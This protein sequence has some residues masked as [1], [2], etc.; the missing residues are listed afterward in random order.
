MEA[1]RFN[2]KV[3][4]VLARY[5][6]QFVYLYVKVFQFLRMGLSEELLWCLSKLNDL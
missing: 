2:N 5:R 1:R 3:A 4:I 6:P